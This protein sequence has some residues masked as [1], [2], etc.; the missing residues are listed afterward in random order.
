VY[1][2]KEAARKI[3]LDAEIEGKNKERFEKNI[4]NLFNGTDIPCLFEKKI[5][6][7]DKLSHLPLD[8]ENQIQIENL[9]EK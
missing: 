9:S 4:P 8:L 2:I 6:Y 3:E 5:T 7:L 1:R